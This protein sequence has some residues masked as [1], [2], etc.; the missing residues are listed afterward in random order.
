[1][2]P[3][4]DRPPYDDRDRSRRRG[5]RRSKRR[6]RRDRDDA[7]EGR[8]DFRDGPPR[9]APPPRR[10]TPSGPAPHPPDP[11]AH[12]R[13]IIRRIFLGVVAVGLLL[14]A[15]ALR[16]I[17]NPLLIG[18]LVAYILNPIV[19]W[20]EAHRVRRV[21]A[22]ILIYV[23]VLVPCLMGLILLGTFVYEDASALPRFI[24]GEETYVD[25]NQN[26][27]W[28]PAEPIIHDANGDGQYDP[29]T[30]KYLDLNGNGKWDPAEPPKYDANHNGKYD[31][32]LLDKLFL[33]LWEGDRFEDRNHNGRFDPPEKLTKDVNGNGRYD[34]KDGD[35]F[36]DLN[37]NG[38]FDPPEKLTKDVNGNGRYDPKDGDQFEDLNHNGRF[39]P[40]DNLLADYNG[41]GECDL[42]LA[43]RLFALL[44]GGKGPGEA[45]VD[46]DA[47]LAKI[48]ASMSQNWKRMIKIVADQ[49]GK[50][51]N[52][53][54]DV[55][56]F[57]VDL[58]LVAIYTFFFLL[59]MND[60][61]AVIFKYIPGPTRDKVEHIL[62][63]IHKSVSSFFRGR[64]MVCAIV[65]VLSAIGLA[66]FKVRFAILLG[67]IIGVGDLVPF[68]GTIMGLFPAMLFSWLDYQN[69][70]LLAGTV[71]WFTAVQWLE[72]MV[73]IPLVLGKEVEMHPVTLIV[74][75]L[76]GAEL[77]GLFGVLIA[78]PLACI[79][80]ILG[81]ELVLPELERLSRE[82]D[83]T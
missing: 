15:Y 12:R 18:L 41:N 45:G 50:L 51:A 65:G 59:R 42:G 5:P 74:S 68:L 62:L 72:G 8:D 39:D 54:G 69:I 77:F 29:K 3:E 21:L 81:S 30:D 55:I 79:F 7:P 27:R 36:E 9:G 22:V 35:Q 6:S 11:A 49:S 16:D 58:V 64:L 52:T 80:K 61:G 28:D 20:L 31:P 23:V 48:K 66:I 46:A 83:W 71:I 40:G 43:K 44:P 57:L 73:I 63:R 53:V 4:D 38:R 56:V 70:W 75:L 67:L 10:G 2:A 60:I 19:N 78:I 25:V 76:I 47:V 32:G 37:H 14:A 1:M 34:P 13:K 82:R 26:G 33:V 17:F 24:I